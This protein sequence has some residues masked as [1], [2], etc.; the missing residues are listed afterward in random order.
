MRT[1]TYNTTIDVVADHVTQLLLDAPRAMVQL[2]PIWGDDDICAN[3][4]DA[5]VC[6]MVLADD[7]DFDHV[8]DLLDTWFPTR[9]R[10]PDRPAGPVVDVNAEF[11]GLR[12]SGPCTDD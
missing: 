3:T 8:C 1:I 11:T 5:I 2:Q 6:V 4:P 10:C 7:D 9:P 12:P